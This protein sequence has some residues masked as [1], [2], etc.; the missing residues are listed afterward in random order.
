MKSNKPG[1]KFDIFISYSSDPDWQV[2]D[3]GG[4]ITLWDINTCQQMG[5]PSQ[6]K[7]SEIREYLERLL[8]EC[9]GLIIIYGSTTVSWVRGQ[10]LNCRKVIQ[11]REHPLKAIAV[12]EGPPEPKDSLDLKLKNMHILNCRLSPNKSLLQSFINNLHQGG[13]SCS[14]GQGYHPPVP[15]ASVAEVAGMPHEQVMNV[16]EVFRRSDR[17]F[18]M[19]YS[20]IPLTPDTILDISHE[21][22]IR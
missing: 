2:G 4:N 22:L 17:S 1:Y 11:K 16:V 19:P 15:L 5:L 10:L 20:G 8:L 21:S 9:D 3:Q 14:P 18:V 12:Y 6:G 7:P 13:N